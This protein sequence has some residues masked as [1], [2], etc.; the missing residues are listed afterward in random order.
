MTRPVV[1]MFPGQGAQYYQMAREL[2]DTHPRFKLWMQFCDEIARPLLNASL[3]DTIYQGEASNE[4]DRITLTNPALLAVEFSLAKIIMEMGI[5]PD[6]LVGYSLG[7]YCGGGVGGD[8]NRAGVCVGS[9][10]GSNAR[11]KKPTRRHAGNYW[12]RE[13]FD[14]ISRAF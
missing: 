5:Q 1:F 2:Y 9:G 3:V 13:C 4:F 11:G 8:I 14:G 12:P 7:V 10:C 6:F